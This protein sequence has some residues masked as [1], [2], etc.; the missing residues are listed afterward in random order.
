MNDDKNPINK[1]L[2]RQRFGSSVPHYD[3]AAKPQKMIAEQLIG[4]I[5]TDDRLPYEGDAFEV[6]CGTGLLSQLLIGRY[7]DGKR[8]FVFNDLSPEM[9]RSLRTKIGAKHTFIS[10]DAEHIEWPKPLAL[11]AS[12]SCIQWWDAPLSFVAKSSLTLRSG[13]VLLYS[14]FLPDNLNELRIVTGRG[15]N[16]PTEPEHRMVLQAVGFKEIHI[17]T[18]RISMDFEG[19]MPLLKHLKLTGT[20]GIGDNPDQGFWSSDKLH[21]MESDYRRLNELT[22]TAPLPLTYSALLVYAKKK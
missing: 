4:M 20:N 3:Q 17:R 12:S 18:L 15:L 6:G 2:I 21:R 22:D 13:G 14:T 11:V 19:I 1:S 8:N 9:E 5:P 16:Y 7:D 10:G